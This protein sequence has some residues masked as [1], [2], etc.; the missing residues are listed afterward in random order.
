MALVDL[1]MVG[2]KKGG[3]TSVSE[4]VAIIQKVI[5][6]SGLKNTLYPMS[7]VVEGDV[8]E[9]FDLVNDMRK[10]LIDKGYTRIETSIRIQEDN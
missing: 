6:D 7:T 1:T 3:G 4:S 2:R 10:A 5:D 8:E 9:I